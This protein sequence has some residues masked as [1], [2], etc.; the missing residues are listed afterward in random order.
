[1]HVSPSTMRTV[2]IITEVT[3][4][5]DLNDLNVSHLL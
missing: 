3:L 1:M 2:N 5:Y 4:R